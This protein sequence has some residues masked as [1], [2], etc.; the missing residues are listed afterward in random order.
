MAR[1]SLRLPSAW[2]WTGA[3]AAPKATRCSGISHRREALGCR[4]AFLRR[5]DRRQA[6]CSS[7]ASGWL[8][9]VH[10][11]AGARARGLNAFSQ[12]PPTLTMASGAS[13]GVGSERSFCGL[14]FLATT[15]ER[16][17]LRVI[18]LA[19]LR[20][21]PAI[22]TTRALSDHPNTI[23]L[24]LLQLMSQ[25]PG[26][27][28]HLR[29][30]DFG[31]QEIEIVHNLA[32]VWFVAAAAMNKAGRNRYPYLFLKPTDALRQQF[33]FSANVLLLFHRYP[34]IDGRLLDAVDRIL[35]TN[36][37]RLDR[38]CVILVTNADSVDGE[39]SRI[40]STTEARVVV[41]FI[42]RELL[43]GT[44]EKD[45]LTVKRLKRFLYT[46]DLFSISSALK[47]DRYFFGRRD[48]IQQLIGKYQ[49]GENSSV[50]GLR[51]IG[52]TSVLWAVVRELKAS[53]VPVAFIDCSDPQ[54]HKVSWNQ[55]LYR[56]K[57]SL[58]DASGLGERGSSPDRYSEQ[59]ASAAFSSDLDLLKR[60]FQKPSLVIFDE[61][62]NLSFDLSP[63]HQW[64]SGG[65]YLSFW[66]TIRSTYQQTPNLFSFCVCGVNPRALEIPTVPGGFDNPLYRYIEP[67]YLGFFRVEDV[68]NMLEYIGGYMG[69]TFDR[70]VFTYLT[71]DF[72]GHPF[73]IRQAASSLYK[74]F[75]RPDLPRTIHI[76]KHIYKEQCREIVN[77]L[78]D[79]V[80]L[81]LR[82]LRE[83]YSDEYKLLKYLAAGQHDTFSRFAADDPSWV[84]H[85][86]GYGLIV[87]SQGKYH[88]RINIVQTTVE[89]EA[90]HL[91]SPDTIEE[92]WELLSEARNRFE[93][94]LRRLV[95]TL[96]GVSL[97]AAAAKQAMIDAM[98]NRFQKDRA[99]DLDFVKIFEDELYLNDL[100]RVIENQWILFRNAFHDDL[101][102][103][104]ECMDN[105][106]KYRADAHAKDV[107]RSCFET[108]MASINWLQQC[109]KDST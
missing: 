12:T 4:G 80:V 78:F 96:L 37:N 104:S 50:F 31:P 77:S 67:R 25:Q 65:E 89:S 83:R 69:M 88:F 70:E 34:S 52:K 102:R 24:S 93:A 58:F 108:A 64:R 72:G 48:D 3:S 35:A 29:M 47:T 44:K 21:D 81:I 109:L 45:S 6:R 10:A 87:P 1:Q 14:R 33:S 98:K 63:S 55:A 91:K 27:L 26:L 66:Q 105:A 79:Y 22:R 74:T 68:Q 11:T 75:A 94:D 51:R 16:E 73:L 53:N 106:N 95:R 36:P 101:A 60:Q 85:L 40:N 107:S 17:P 100:K 90:R 20:S 7:E 8:M 42:Y 61:I 49:T 59:D 62:E 56:V 71:D 15:P 82:V 38:L 86:L 76:S 13:L 99:K 5:S 32:T 46:R 43:G 103:F 41:P 39:L 9:V 92:R 2:S 84:A 97:G 28:P 30:E 18:R 57:Q 54:F 19:D 23:G